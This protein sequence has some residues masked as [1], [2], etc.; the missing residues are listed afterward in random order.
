[1]ENEELKKELLKEIE[2][3]KEKDK[4]KQVIREINNQMLY[5][6]DERKKVIDFILK[7]REKNLEEYRDDEDKGIEY[8]NHELY[9][10]EEQFKL[11]E[12]RLREF[13][14]LKKSPYFGKVC[15]EDRY[16][17]MNIYI[18]RFGLTNKEEYEPLIVDWRS[19]VSSLFYQGKLGECEY[20]TPEGKEKANIL[21]KRQ[22]IIKNGELQGMFDSKL[23]VKDEILQFILSQNTSEKLKDIVMTIQ[24]EQD[25]LIRQPRDSV[26]VVNGVAGSG[27]TTIALHRVAYLLYNYRA[28]LEDKVLIL[29]PNSIFMDY[30]SMVLPTLGEEGVKQTTFKEFASEIIDQT[31]DIM[32]F[33]GYMENILED[34]AEFIQDIKYKRSAQ[35]IKDMDSLV[36]DLEEN[37]FKIKDVKFYGKVIAKKSDIEDMMNI[38]FKS[39]PL[40]KRT[41][42]ILRI[43]F[44]KINDERNNIVKKIQEDYENMISNMGEEELNDV[45]TNLEFIRRN[46]IREV[47]EEVI[48]IKKDTLEWIKNPN[49]IDV[50]NK[51]NGNKRII[52]ED[53]APILYLKIKLEGLKYKKHLKHIVIDEAQDY[54]ILQ[55]K[56]LR[57]LTGCNSFTIVGDVNQKI[58]PIDED[59]AM[60]NLHKVF[61]DLN[62]KYFPLN[63]SYRSTSEIMN[64]ASRYIKNNNVVGVRN[65]ECVEEHKYVNDHDIVDAIINDIM[66]FKESG[67]ES[68]AVVCRSL[69]ETKTLGKLISQ[70]MHITLFDSEN[71]IYS[72]G[73]VILPS[74]FAKGLEFDAVIMIDNF[75]D[76]CESLNKIK[77][78]MAT[79]AL[80]KLCVY[81][82]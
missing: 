79:R 17:E 66:K 37:Y 30:I 69:R 21:S 49:V 14:I 64:Y 39:M 72:K 52:Y 41:R 28:E 56:V 13:T 31:G 70:K 59:C 48:R 53:L 51:Y 65:G 54:S 57:E 62:V 18:G 11:I 3:N 46:K 19:P 50:Y 82:V 40:F 33:G 61:P 12:K 38:Y 44:S 6:V 76:S 45:G 75:K 55:F 47:I 16:G 73:E 32:D 22:F 60:I 27:K 10:K 35:Y 71:I 36:E 78:I 23:N 63:T 1:M 7:Y 24:K 58:I 20:T 80:H 42:R 15:F 67:Y 8:F 4:L 34:K 77:Y 2:L 43:I 81:K 25:D 9:V 5:F 26:I 74:Y 68:I 29:G